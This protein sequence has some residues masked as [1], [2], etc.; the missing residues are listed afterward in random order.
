MIFFKNIDKTINRHFFISCFVVNK[1]V[2]F[3]YYE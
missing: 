1:K 2:V 3:E